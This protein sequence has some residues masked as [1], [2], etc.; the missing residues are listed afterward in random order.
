MLRALLLGFGQILDPAFRRPL[1]LGALLALAGGVARAWGVGWGVAWLAG[2]QGWLAAAAAGAGGVL[3]VLVAVWWLFLP[4]LRAIAN[5]FVDG[6]AAAV[7]RRHYPALPPATGAGTGAQLRWGLG[8]AARMAGLTLLLLPLA[9]LLP[10]VG[11]VALWAVAAIALGEGLFL[12][13]AQ[14]RMG[15]AE[16]EALRRARRGAIWTLGGVLALAGLVAP[17]G[18]LVPVLGTAAMVHLLHRDPG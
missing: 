5:R 17:L 15:V 6:V 3:A 13:V 16:A 9:L 2:G 11:A 14:R 1:L 8:H 18:L 4:L 10:L 12:G 7:E